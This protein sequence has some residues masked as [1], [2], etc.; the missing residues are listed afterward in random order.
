MNYFR[1]HNRTHTFAALGFRFAAPAVIY[2]VTQGPK[3]RLYITKKLKY[4]HKDF[5]CTNVQEYSE[6][7]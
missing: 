1:K 7:L 4:L 3:R 6:V 5:Q 2:Q